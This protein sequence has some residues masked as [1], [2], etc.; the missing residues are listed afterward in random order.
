MSQYS[1]SVESG[2][3]EPSP[4]GSAGDGAAVARTAESLSAAPSGERAAGSV[5]AVHPGQLLEEPPP[6][7][8][9]QHRISEVQTA[10]YRF[11][12]YAASRSD[13]EL[14]KALIDSLIPVLRKKPNALTPED[15]AVLWDGYNRMS[16]L[17]APATDES[18]DITDQ[19]RQARASPT[20]SEAT[21]TWPVVN[22]IRWELR[23]TVYLLITMVA[24]FLITQAYVILLTDALQDHTELRKEYESVNA[25]IGDLRAASPGI[26]DDAAPV[27]PLV[28][29]RADLDR[30]LEVTHRAEARLMEI[31]WWLYPE[32]AA[33]K[34]S[35]VKDSEEQIKYV[36]AIESYSRSLLSILSQYILPLILG[37][38]GAIAYLVRRSLFNLSYNSYAPSFGG[39]FAMRMCL[40][41]LL[42]VIGG[43]M[44][45]LDQA[46]LKTYNL[47]TVVVAFLM[48]YSVEFA[49]TLFDR[50]IERG[51][52]L[53]TAQV[54][55]SETPNAQPS[56][57][58][59]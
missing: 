36:H 33:S 31:W 2:R 11:L 59:P 25:Q 44:F 54:R 40:G 17:V 4:G 10:V 20:R 1:H 43:I 52:S 41:G 26:K 23:K 15:E 38:L 18:L 49:F 6:D 7:A 21:K 24:M 45:S 42:G 29:R 28:D 35:E 37:L 13:I 19:I 50:L 14:D 56:A 53:F 27:K 48:G 3:A 5:E 46:E 47:S 34:D 39:Q 22:R 8:V 12:R 57:S 51:R 55:S 30:K 16:K 58:K 9:Q 32:P